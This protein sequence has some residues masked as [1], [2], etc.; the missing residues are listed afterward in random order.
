[1]PR[2]VFV[3]SHGNA[4]DVTLDQAYQVQADFVRDQPLIGYKL[5][6][7][8]SAKQQQMGINTPIYGAIT[9]PMLRQNAVALCDFIQPR[10]EPEIAVRLGSKIASN[11]SPQ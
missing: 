11:A 9:A 7:V 1:M 5:G 8:S 6:L 3:H 2:G 4:L 10:V